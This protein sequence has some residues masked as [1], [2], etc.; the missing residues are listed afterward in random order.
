MEN[1]VKGISGRTVDVA[2]RLRG[3]PDLVR[4]V[5][6]DHA[7]VEDTT[8]MQRITS[9]ELAEVAVSKKGAVSLAGD[10][11]EETFLPR[12]LGLSFGKKQSVARALCRGI[13]QP[14]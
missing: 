6:G 3:F 4:D 7:S 5:S 8:I 1:R 2:D 10:I 9:A 13:F 14:I 12:V 11:R